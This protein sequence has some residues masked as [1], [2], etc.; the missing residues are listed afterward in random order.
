MRLDVD[1]YPYTASSTILL[2]NSID[3]SERVMITWCTPY[4]EM[5]GR[6]LSDIVAEWGVSENEAV[7]RL[8]P[9]GA[10]Y[11]QMDEQDL[12]RVLANPNTMIGSDGLPHDQIPHPRLWGTFPRILG[13]YVRELGVLNLEQAIHRMTGVPARVFGLDKRGTLAPGMMAD[14]VMF[15]PDTVIDTATFDDPIQPATGISRVMT[16]GRWIWQD[17]QATG[18]MPGRHV[19]RAA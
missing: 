5:A 6:D 18:A 2:K 11:F 19:V 9:A 7:D 12:Q 14:V 15:D 10:V 4:P 17:G 8:S 16:N 13:R 1:V 3:R